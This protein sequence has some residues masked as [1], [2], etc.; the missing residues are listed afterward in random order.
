MSQQQASVGGPRGPQGSLLRLPFDGNTPPSVG[1]GKGGGVPSFTARLLRLI[2]QRGLTGRSDRTQRCLGGSD[3]FAIILGKTRE[4]LTN[5]RA[6][7]LGR[8]RM[9][10]VGYAVVPSQSLPDRKIEQTNQSV[11]GRMNGA[12]R[13]D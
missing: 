11:I 13:Q 6:E 10:P 7:L 3:E 2:E 8:V 5:L 4:A 1:R 9:M 12:A